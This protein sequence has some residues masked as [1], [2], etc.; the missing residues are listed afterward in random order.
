M[1]R[2]QKSLQSIGNGLMVQSVK[3]THIIHRKGATECAFMEDTMRE[4]K[5]VCFRLYLLL[6][7]KRGFFLARKT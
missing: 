6:R 7:A 2:V 5:K 1:R 4:Q 3:S